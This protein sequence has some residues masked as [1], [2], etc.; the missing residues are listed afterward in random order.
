MPNAIG[1][2]EL[3]SIAIGFEVQDTM[4]K[5]STVRLLLARTICSGKYAIIVGGE[6]SA[7]NTSVQAGL[8][9]AKDAYIDSLVIPNV[10]ESIFSALANTVTL[11][12]EER[13]ALGVVETFTVA[14]VLEGADAAAKAANIKVF[15]IHVAMA[16]GG[17]G[18]LMITGDVSSVRA[19]VEAASAVAIEGGVLVGTTVIPAPSQEL[20]DE[21]V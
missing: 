14:A 12:A 18:F 15:R 6:V 11:T 9:I 19:G 2:I 20:F 8:Q 13:G 16:I 3:S 21:Y 10:H 1:M 17:K 5:A 7:V 4:L